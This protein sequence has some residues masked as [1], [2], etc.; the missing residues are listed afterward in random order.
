[1]KGLIININFF[2]KKTKITV[3]PNMPLNVKP[4]NNIFDD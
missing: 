2:H 4:S 1:M 3:M